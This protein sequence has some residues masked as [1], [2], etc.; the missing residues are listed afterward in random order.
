MKE[1]VETQDERIEYFSKQNTVDEKDLEEALLF[2]KQKKESFK[3]TPSFLDRLD[4]DDQE[5][6]VELSELQVQHVD[7]INE[8]EKTRGLLRI[9]NNINNEQKKEIGTLQKRLGQ[10]KNEYQEQFGEYQ[11]L[12]TMRANK[13][14]KLETQLRESAY[15]NLQ[16]SWNKSGSDS[17]LMISQETSVHTASGQSLFEIHIQRISL[18]QVSS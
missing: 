5:I 11:K 18:T 16:K 3:E 7:A 8:L 6:K 15:G 10:V 17:G 2:L 9:Q 12:L 13:I 14:Q 1:N 4:T